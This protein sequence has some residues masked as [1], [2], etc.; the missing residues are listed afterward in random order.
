LNH[1]HPIRA[2]FTRQTRAAVGPIPR[3]GLQVSCP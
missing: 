2:F 3:D 1:V